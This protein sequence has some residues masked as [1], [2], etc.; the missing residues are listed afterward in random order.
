MA[1]N[2][3]LEKVTNLESSIEEIK[4]YIKVLMDNLQI[5]Q[6][7]T[8]NINSYLIMKIVTENNGDREIILEEVKMLY[9]GTSEKSFNENIVPMIDEMIAIYNTSKTITEEDNEH[10]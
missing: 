5:V 2:K 9:Q 3:L 7:V 8:D 10:D 1:V 4:Q 6:N